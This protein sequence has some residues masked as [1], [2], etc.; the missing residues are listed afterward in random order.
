VVCFCS[1]HDLQS[2]R[3]GIINDRG[4]NTNP[5]SSGMLFNRQ[6][7]QSSAMISNPSGLSSNNGGGDAWRQDAP[8]LGTQEFFESPGKFMCSHS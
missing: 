6:I 3:P 8:Q 1:K 5:N 4:N 7:N 2:S